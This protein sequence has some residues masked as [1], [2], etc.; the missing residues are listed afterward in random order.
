M[1]SDFL[2]I[3]QDARQIQ[4]AGLARQHSPTYAYDTCRW[5]KLTMHKALGLRMTY[6]TRTDYSGAR[7]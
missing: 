7:R 3:L 1:A 5:R 4:V 2:S 6:T